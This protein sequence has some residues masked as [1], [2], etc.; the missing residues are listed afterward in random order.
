MIIEYYLNSCNLLNENS[1]DN[2]RILYHTMESE[3][4]FKRNILGYMIT[5][6]KQDIDLKKFMINN[7]GPLIDEPYETIMKTIRENFKKTELEESII[8]LEKYKGLLKVH[9]DGIPYLENDIKH[10]EVDIQQ[11]KDILKE[12]NPKMNDSQKKSP[13]VDGKSDQFSKN[14]EGKNKGNAEFIPAPDFASIIWKGEVYSL[15]PRQAKVIKILKEQYDKGPPE[16][17]EQ[18]IM[19]KLG[20]PSS[21]LKDTFRKSDLWKKLVIP[22]KKKGNFKLDI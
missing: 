1:T 16:L 8:F 13:S 4:E 20:T 21:N 5:N 7:L 3:L 22:G 11:M 10:I 15:S 19:E 9:V 2:E 18:Y 17:S 12:Q 6:N 14:D